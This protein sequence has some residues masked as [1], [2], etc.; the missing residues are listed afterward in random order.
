MEKT[1]NSR[2]AACAASEDTITPEE[3]YYM[4]KA[5]YNDFLRELPD[6]E[7]NVEYLNRYAKET[8][9][10]KTSPLVMMFIAYCGGLVKGMEVMGNLLDGKGKDN[11]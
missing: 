3:F 7:D 4:L 5:L 2:S 11:A 1:H 9:L 10:D 6:D 8:G